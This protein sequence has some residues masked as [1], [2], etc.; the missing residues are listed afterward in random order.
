MQLVLGLTPLEAGLW[1]L[2]EAV[3]FILGPNLAP[4]IVRHVRPAYLMAGGF[5]LAG[6]GP[7]H[8][9]LDHRDE[10]RTACARGHRLVDHLASGS[11]RS[12]A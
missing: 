12:S 5:L 1:S 10:R 2:P 3:G 9:E 8:P 6:V 7:A 4:R 11:G